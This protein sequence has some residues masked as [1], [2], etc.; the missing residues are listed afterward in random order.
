LK[1]RSGESGDF[2]INWN[3]DQGPNYMDFSEVQSSLGEL[4]HI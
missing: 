3:F 2:E 1:G 4:T